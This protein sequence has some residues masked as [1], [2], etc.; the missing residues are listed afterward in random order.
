MFVHRQEKT[1]VSAKASEHIAPH[2]AWPFHR[3][4]GAGPCI[5]RTIKDKGKSDKAESIDPR[6]SIFPALR[7]KY[8]F[9]LAAVL[10]FRSAATVPR[11][12]TRSCICHG[13]S[14]VYTTRSLP[15]NRTVTFNA[16]RKNDTGVQL[17]ATVTRVKNCILAGPRVNNGAVRRHQRSIFATDER[18]PSLRS[19]DCLQRLLFNSP[20]IFAGKRDKKFAGCLENVDRMEAGLC[21]EEWKLFR[22]NFETRIKKK[23][24]L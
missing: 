20:E 11:C 13:Y 24:P 4:A 19:D 15:V 9:F 2:N 5:A 7:W 10:F 3:R 16:I 17:N 18:I 6:C 8:R 23:F 14:V 21:K 12:L 22:G 1:I